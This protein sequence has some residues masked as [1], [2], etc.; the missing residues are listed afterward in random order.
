MREVATRFWLFTFA[1]LFVFGVVYYRYAQSELNAAKR[2]VLRKQKAVA[3]ALGPEVGALR[4]RLDEWLVWLASD[5]ARFGS[6]EAADLQHLPESASIYVRMALGQAE[7]EQER[8]KAIEK[9]RHDGFTACLFVD[10]NGGQA[11][12]PPCRTTAQ[13]EAGLMCNQWSVCEEPRPP[14]DMHWLQEALVVVDQG[15]VDALEA[16]QN[17]YEVRAMDLQL[18]EVSKHQVPFAAAMARRS[19]FF[20]AV[21]DEETAAG[22]PAAIGAKP[23]LGDAGVEAPVESLLEQVRAAPHWV[24][25]GLWSLE[26]S[27]LLAALRLRAEGRVVSVGPARHRAP[28]SATELRVAR[29]QLRQANDCSLGVQLRERIF[30]GDGD[31]PVPGNS[32]DE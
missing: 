18:G 5:A 32:S 24:R 21:L 6:F 22:A 19:K 1:G 28:R 14:Y 2:D 23:E 11:E 30:P 10:R 16:S 8:R 20:A 9:S 15:W 7:Q 31:E 4:E 27:Q 3:A 26:S 17:A 13:C 25:I 29:A 12:G